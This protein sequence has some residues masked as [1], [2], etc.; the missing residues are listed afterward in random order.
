MSADK[1]VMFYVNVKDLNLTK[2]VSFYEQ[3][4][5]ALREMGFEV[6]VTNR[7]LDVIFKKYDFIYV[8]WWSY[9]FFPAVWSKITKKKIVVTGAFHYSTPL[10][11]GTDFVRRS[12]LF[13]TLVKAAL[14]LADANIFVSNYEMKDVL[15]NLSTCNP[16]VVH[17]G[18]DVDKYLPSKLYNQ[19]DSPRTKISIISWL[20]KNNIERKCLYEA[21]SAFNS[22]F[23][24]GAN[25]ELHIAGRS[26]PGSDAFFNFIDGLECRDRIFILGH[27]TEGE[28]VKLLQ[29]SDIF[30]SPTRYEGFGVAI[31]EALACGCAVIT[32]ANGATSEVAGDCAL[33]ADPLDVQDI[34]SKLLILSNDKSLRLAMGEK[35]SNRIQTHFSYKRHFESLRSI[36]SSVFY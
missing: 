16:Q 10:M 1:K 25:I 15:N 33:Y 28:K 3:D 7:Y 13:K 8:W 4:I 34:A 12:I 26:G 14:R 31:A 11:T 20:E 19:I 23:L 24:L 17:H 18:I 6:F 30:L 27:I 22:A 29:T 32:S 36:I 35:A 21:V 5:R 9:A 2:D